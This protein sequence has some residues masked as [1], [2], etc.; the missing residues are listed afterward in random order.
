MGSDHLFV[1]ALNFHVN[2][3]LFTGNSKGNLNSIPQS[4]QSDKLPIYSHPGGLMFNKAHQPLGI[5]TTD[6]KRGDLQ[7]ERTERGIEISDGTLNHRNYNHPEPVMASRISTP[8]PFVNSSDLLANSWSHSVSSWGNPC[9]SSTQKLT[10]VQSQTHPSFNSSACWSR[11]SQLCDQSHEIFRDRWHVNGSSRPNPIFASEPPTCNGFYHGFSSRSKELSGCFP[12]SVFDYPNCN[13]GDV[14]EKFFKGA[15]FVDLKSTK[16]MNSDLTKISSNEAVH[17]K[18]LE[19]IS[20]KGK[21]LDRLASLPWLRTKPA[22]KNEATGTRSNPISVDLGFFQPPSDHLC[23]KEIVD[24]ASASSGGDVEANKEIVGSSGN[25]RILGFPVFEN[26]CAYKTDSPLLISPSEGE[27]LK[28]KGKHRLIDINVACDPTVLESGKETSAEPLAVEKETNEEF[29]NF[30]NCIDLNSCMSEE[31]EDALAPSENPSKRIAVEIDLE[32]PAIQEGEESILPEEEHPQN[33]APLQ[34]PQNVVEHPED[35]F[36]RTAAE[37]IFAMSVPSQHQNIDESASHPSESSLADPLL[38]FV[39][40]VSSCA[41]DLDCKFDKELLEGNAGNTEEFSTSEIDYFEAMTLQLIETKEEDYLPK[42]LVPETRDPEENGASS[43]PSRTR[44]GQSRRGRQRRD[45]Q[46]D[47]LPGLSSLARHEV[48]EDL[49]TF[50]GL[51]RATGH[52][53]QSGLARR[54]GGGAGRRRR[55]PV[56]EPSPPVVVETPVCTS[57]ME[58]LQN[59]EVGLEDRSLTGWGKTTRRPRRQRCPPAGNSLAIALT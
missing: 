38:W 24:I 22:C 21:C 7:R 8:Y 52:N 28:I 44:R 2:A 51:M 42:L 34:S 15:S 25:R 55:Q 16:D 27:D 10:S 23:R 50:G 5:F 36:V 39:D 31:D 18:D 26:R 14:S 57:L 59:I 41:G 46:R 17:L 32:A 4:F 49:Q 9:G 56:V 29:T 6:H 48:T 33:E 20:E 58:H 19:V 13:K 1:G 40:V 53:W 3:T 54:N 37:A 30:R 11:N 35:E 45:F 47:I 43:L 12:S